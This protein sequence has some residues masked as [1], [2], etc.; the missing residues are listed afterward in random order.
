MKDDIAVVILAAGKGTRMKSKQAKVLHSLCGKSMLEHLL[1]TSKRVEPSF[2]G[3]VVGYQQD[4]IRAAFKDEEITFIEQKEQKGTGHALLQA[5]DS[6]K[7]FV[8]TLVVLNGDVPLIE[9]AT[10][11]KLMAAVDNDTLGAVLTTEIIDP[12]G[13]GRIIRDEHNQLLEIIEEKDLPSSLTAVNEINTGVYAF[14]SPDVFTTLHKL[15]NN[16][17][18]QEHYLTDVVKIWNQEGKKV[19]AV[20]VEDSYQ[21]QGINDR[22]DLS[23][24]EK[25]LFQKINKKHQQNGVTIVDPNSTFIELDVILDADVTILPQTMLQGKTKIAGDSIIGP[26][27]TLIDTVVGRGSKIY[28]SYLTASHVGDNTQVGPYAHLRPGTVLVGENKVG[29]FVEI[30]KSTIGSKT[31]VSHLSYVGDTITGQ[32]CNIGAGTITANYDGKHKHQTQLND[33][34]FIGS[35]STLIAPLKIGLRGKT[36]AGAVVNKDVADDTTVIGVPARPLI[37]KKKED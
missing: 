7:D 5:E 21:V 1:I 19:K 8:G 31:K 18:Q 30:K 25:N 28:C 33:F 9:A 16:N 11:K 22:V 36:G 26:Q 27:T 14:A 35:N 34:V 23:E 3:V 2:L 29:N 15:S 13:Y 17:Q 6:L 10:I 20:K 4:L 37:E 12:Y 32:A 24:V